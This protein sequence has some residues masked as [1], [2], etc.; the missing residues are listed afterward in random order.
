MFIALYCG[1]SIPLHAQTD[2]STYH[3]GNFRRGGM[4][5]PY[6]LLLPPSMDQ[7]K[8][9][10][11]IFLHGAL[12][13]GTDNE[14]Q[15]TLGGEVFLRDSIRSRYPAFVLFPQCPETDSWAYFDT[16]IDYE[17]G[18][19]TDWNFPFHRLPTTV[20][21]VLMKL[22]DSLTGTGS[23]DKGRIYIAG[24]SQ[25][26]MGVLDLCARYPLLFAAGISICG[27]G[28]PSTAK[29]FG[30]K[31]AIWLFHGG[32]DD[33]VPP[34]FSRQYARRLKRYG[35]KNRYTEYPGV[36]HDSWVQAF[37]EPGLMPWLFSQ[38]QH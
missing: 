12:E 31:V 20:S 28:E 4:V 13:K 10:L 9:P 34:S 5:L 37:A 22:V 14:R 2:L 30:D 21:Q 6:R 16:Q 18:L 15:L 11:V 38:H 8:Y 3:K 1:I 25:G 32:K 7:G 26:G 33:I 17:T 36:G 35:T 29:L 19:A 24:L 27:A 23:I